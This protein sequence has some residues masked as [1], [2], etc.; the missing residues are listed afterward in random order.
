MRTSE[1]RAGWPVAAQHLSY[2]QERAAQSDALVSFLSRLLRA[3]EETKDSREV[4]GKADGGELLLFW[5]EA[6]ALKPATQCAQRQCSSVAAA[7][8]E[9][10][11]MEAGGLPKLDTCSC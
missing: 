10:G 3:G 7:G 6:E 1:D 2:G 4:L 8:F 5:T 11:Y 9:E